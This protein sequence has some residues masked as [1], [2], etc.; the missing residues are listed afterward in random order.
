MTLV[1]THDVVAAVVAGL[2]SGT[3]KKF[4]DGVA[5]ADTTFPYGI[6]YWLPGGGPDRTQIATIDHGHTRDWLDLQVSV[7]GQTAVQARWMLQKARE[8]MLNLSNFTAPSGYAFSHVT[9]ELPGG[10][11]RDDSLGSE[12]LF[13][14]V[15]RYQLWV[16]P[17]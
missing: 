14:G 4:G 15:D 16:F 11:N 5:P 13:Q 1:P 3:G 9:L 7:W 6:V 10:V 17:S 2:A 12:P 8:T